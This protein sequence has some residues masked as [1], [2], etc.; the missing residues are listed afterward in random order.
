[1]GETAGGACG[2]RGPR[3]SLPIK[4]TRAYKAEAPNARQRDQVSSVL[5]KVRGL[6]T[7]STG[8]P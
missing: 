7:G 3:A 1:M 4:K 2:E 8:R 5:E 6:E